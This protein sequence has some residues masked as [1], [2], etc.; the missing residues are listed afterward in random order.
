MLAYAMHLLHTETGCR[1]VEIHP[2]GEHGKRFQIRQWLESHG[3][4]LVEPA[5]KTAYGG[6]YR[7]P[8]AQT[9]VKQGVFLS[10]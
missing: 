8:N 2:D 4:E 3:F 1:R 7:G 10:N 9:P 6:G 5:G